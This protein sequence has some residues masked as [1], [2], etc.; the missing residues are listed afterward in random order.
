MHA[1]VNLMPCR[2]VIFC[3]FMFLFVFCTVLYIR[4]CFVH[5]GF[6]HAV[7]TQ[8]RNNGHIVKNTTPCPNKHVSL[9]LQAVN[10]IIIITFIKNFLKTHRFEHIFEVYKE[11]LY[12]LQST[13]VSYEKNNTEKYWNIQIKPNLILHYW[14]KIWQI[15][16]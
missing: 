16:R 2:N 15:T 13:L 3:V 6:V 5:I 10:G 4:Y 9:F 7:L 8:A 1:D 14:P 12:D 11:I